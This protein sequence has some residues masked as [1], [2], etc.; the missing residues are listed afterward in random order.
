[1]HPR[2]AQI[3]N[4]WGN[5]A[6]WSFQLLFGV[7]MRSREVGGESCNGSLHMIGGPI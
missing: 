6:S 2:L 7:R 3:R 5:G 4:P 1:M